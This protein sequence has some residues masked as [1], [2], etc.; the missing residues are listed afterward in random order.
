M[1][2]VAKLKNIFICD[3]KEHVYCLIL[4]IFVVKINIPHLH[5]IKTDMFNI[6]I[7]GFTLKHIYF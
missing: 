5:C 1:W 2:N 6:Y 3:L 7:T 4:Y